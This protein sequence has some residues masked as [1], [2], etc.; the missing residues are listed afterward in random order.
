MEK[1]G[2]CDTC[3]YG[4]NCCLP[5]KFPVWLCEEYWEGYPNPKD[6]GREVRK[7]EGP[8]LNLVLDIY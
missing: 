3:A 7:E 2:L 4:R 5:A 1:R 6:E 8:G